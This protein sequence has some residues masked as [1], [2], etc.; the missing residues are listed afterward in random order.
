MNIQTEKIMPDAIGFL[1]LGKLGRPIVSN[2]MAAGY[3]LT[4]YNRDASKVD[5]FVERGA[6]R[7]SRPADAVQT[8][9]VVLSLLWDDAS[10]EAIVR[11]EDFLTR[12]GTGGCMCR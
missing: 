5:P 6:V 11:S 12:L 10:V 4:V 9:G 8:G 3:R 1:G 2:L 7:A